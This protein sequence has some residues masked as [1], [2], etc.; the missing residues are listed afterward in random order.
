[1]TFSRQSFKHGWQNAAW[2]CIANATNRS[3]PRF[4]RNKIHAELAFGKVQ[5]ILR[6]IFFQA[7]S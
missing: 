7:P 3:P 4:R 1:M 5:P 2:K 6:V